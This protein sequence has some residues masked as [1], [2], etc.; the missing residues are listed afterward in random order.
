MNKND[1]KIP[2]FLQKTVNIPAEVD[3]ASLR[4]Q[5]QNCETECLENDCD[6]VQEPDESTILKT[7]VCEDTIVDEKPSQKISPMEREALIRS[8]KGMGPEQL[9]I[10]LDNIPIEM[11]YNRLGRELERNKAFINSMKG[12]MSLIENTSKV[13]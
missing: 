10:L 3:V 11:V 1:I 8:V 9:D 5:M 13:H 2:S 7:K 12:A 6:V 4:L